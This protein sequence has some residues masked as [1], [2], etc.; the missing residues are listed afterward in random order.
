M[1]NKE[2]C[3]I[4]GCSNKIAVKIHKLCRTHVNQLYVKGVVDT[5]N[6]RNNKRHKLVKSK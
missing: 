4:K 3:C 1:K 2:E 5:E 6:V